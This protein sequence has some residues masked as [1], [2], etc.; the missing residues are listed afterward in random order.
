MTN[1]SGRIGTQTEVA[2]VKVF[3]DHGYTAVER[4]RLQG[5]NDAG[6]LANV[7]GFIVEIKGGAAAEQ[8]SD[9]QIE[10]WLDRLQEKLSQHKVPHGVL[11]TKRKGIGYANASK[12]WAIWRVQ[13]LIGEVTYRTTLADFLTLLKYGE[14]LESDAAELRPV[15]APGGEQHPRPDTPTA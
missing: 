4:R 10:Q 3:H 2:V 7:P 5:I 12:W 6:D 8:A 15:A 11:I 14:F 1:K 9:A 13:L